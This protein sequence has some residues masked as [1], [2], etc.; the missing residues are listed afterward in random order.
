MTTSLATK[1]L[2]AGLV[3]H[4]MPDEPQFKLKSG[5]TSDIYVDLRSLGHHPQLRREVVHQL[6]AIIPPHIVAELRAN[7]GYVAGLPLGGIETAAL[8]SDRTMLPFLLIRNEV[9]AHGTGRL[10]EAQLT[11]PTSVLLVDDVM[12]TGS[13]VRETIA[14]FKAADIPI[15][16]IGVVCVVNRCVDDTAN[17]VVP[18]TD[19]PLYA[20][21]TL[22]DLRSIPTST[23]PTPFVK[24][25]QQTHN[26]HA[27]RLF[28]LMVAKQTNVCWS[29][30]V[31]SPAELLRVFNIIAPHIAIIKVHFDAIPQLS[32]DDLQRLQHIA[33]Q[34]NV[35]VMADRKFADIGATVEKQ[36]AQHPAARGLMHCSTVHS[37]AGPGAIRVLADHS[38]SSVLVAQMSNEGS[39]TDDCYARQT[40]E[41]AT[42]HAASVMGLVCQSRADCEAGD[43]FVYMTPGVHLERI[44]DGNDQRYR[45]CHTA[46]R[47][48]RNDV[49]IV[50]RGIS[51]AT[52][53][54]EVAKLYQAAAWGCLL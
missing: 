46:I 50:G 7:G 19:I 10:V 27:S 8:V 21:M 32:D 51:E 49:V 14:R 42:L 33:T 29:A 52:Y 48:Q 24:R 6:V 30:D 44:T 2:A 26:V 34:H 9:K 23:R 20:L 16:I 43:G 15:Q 13:T 37:I 41:M 40:A 53:P 4:A 54:V 1:L 35:L 39:I 47:V 45:D 28:E 17:Q 25:E 12:T 3:K 11:S 5:K 31:A 36:L 18:D 22:D 38:I